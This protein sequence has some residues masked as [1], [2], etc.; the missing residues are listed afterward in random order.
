MHRKILPGIVLML[1][2]LLLFAIAPESKRNMQPGYPYN[3]GAGAKGEI[4]YKPADWW[5]IAWVGI[6]NVTDYMIS[7]TCQGGGPFVRPPDWEYFDGSFPFWSQDVYPD[8]R[9]LACEY[10]A[11]SDQFYTYAAGLWVNALCPIIE[12]GD[13]IEWVPKC[14]ETAYAS[15]L[16]AMS[17]P[18]VE[19]IG[20]NDY[21]YLGLCFSTQRIRQG[22]GAGD[23]L[24]A[25]PGSE[26]E[27]Y[28]ARWPFADMLINAKR[29]DSS[30]WVD[31]EKG[32]VISLEDTYAVAGDYIP[33]GD[34]T[35]I[36]IR[37][38]G[39][40][41]GTQLGLRIEERT[42]CWNYPYNDAY[43]FI[44]WKI[45]NMNP[46]RLKD[47]YVAHFMDNDIGAGIDDS[48]QGAWDDMMGFDRTLNLT[49]SYDSDGY[50][51]GW[52][53]KAGYVGGVMCES[54]YGNG[55]TGVQTWLYGDPIDEDLQDALRHEY[56]A[57]TS[58]MTWS[59]PR[60]I[61]QL[62][63]SGPFDLAPFGESGDEVDF[64][65]AIVVGETLDELKERARYAL[66]QF[67]NGYLGFS[68]PPSPT[69]EIVP[70]DETVYL[71]WDTSPES[72]ICPMSGE[73]TFEGYRIYR[74]LT[75]IAGDWELLSDFDIV[76]SQTK[77]TVLVK[78]QRGVT[79]AQIEFLDFIRGFDTLL[80]TSLYTID[81][82]AE[83]HFGVYNV[84]EQTPYHYEPHAEDSGGGYCIKETMTSD[85]YETDPGYIS[86]SIIYMDGFYVSIRDGEYD[87]SQPGADIDPNAGDQFTIRSFKGDK[88]G[89]DFGLQRYYVDEDLIDGV[90]Y[91]YSVNSYSRPLPHYGVEELES[92]MTGKKYWAIP[93]KEAADYQFPQQPEIVRIGGSGDIRFEAHIANPNEVLDTDYKLRFGTTHPGTD[94]A[95]FWQLVRV[96]EDS[97][98]VILIDSST[99]INFESTPIIDGL[100]F[101][102]ATVLRP[103]IDTERVID[104][105]ETGWIWGS[106]DFDFVFTPV[107]DLVVEPRN[108]YLIIFSDTGSY[109]Y[110]GRKT[111]FEVWNVNTEEP[112]DF[113]Y[114]GGENS[115]YPDPNPISINIIVSWGPPRVYITMNALQ[116]DSAFSH[117]DTGDIYLVKLLIRSTTDDEF[118]VQTT[119][120]RPKG[121]Y[122]LEDIRVVPNPYYVSAVWDGPSEFERKVY[123]QG[124]PSKCAIR[125]FNS[126]G[127]LLR[128]IEHDETVATY[129]RPD[130]M[131]EEEV[132][133][134]HAWD[135][136]T[137]GG[138]EVTSG[139]FIYQVVT[140]DGKEKVGKFAVVR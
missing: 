122:T 117:P 23:Y 118:T 65:V 57:R 129:F 49:Y 33:S 74:S 88:H 35:T 77:D 16:G 36:W 135:L 63:S 42:Y 30:T 37:D 12:D 5:M 40:Y 112:A 66:T 55:L 52:M 68:P 140:P 94:S 113:F 67:E 82:D 102:V 60:D 98:E 92:G 72:Y 15:D 64:T 48:D 58:F 133:G 18:E 61:R 128:K 93:R 7:N 70:A 39:P 105:L 9:G 4:T 103:V 28:Q 87:P 100:S 116:K 79:N 22:T 121:T 91:Y 125:I 114:T 123:F 83:D 96:E 124:L 26:P 32:D 21:S 24:F 14:I 47:V 45:K 136:K 90:T 108:N 1:I 10:P 44:N 50:E 110:Y 81:F 138:Y 3:P 132:Q 43:F 99:Y 59:I 34:A 86:E 95:D 80:T 120:K 84:T 75:G 78:Y 137:D 85:A 69:V 6:G 127:L 139:L 109:D 8:L 71:S 56:M 62:A 130:V 20:G 104:E 31:P 46:Y 126:A 17:I 27:S 111:P 101:Q 19:D 54:P 25:Q 51:P 73:C 41:A 134:S 115:I 13:T 29:P 38:A 97:E 53:T 2:P 89:N 119:S 11:G 107:S 76:G 131:G 106:S